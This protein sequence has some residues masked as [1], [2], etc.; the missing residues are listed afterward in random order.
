MNWTKLRQQVLKRDNYICQICLKQ[1]DKLDVHHI[2]PR[3]KQG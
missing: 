1:F 2:I 3:K